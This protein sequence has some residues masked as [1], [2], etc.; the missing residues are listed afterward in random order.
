MKREQGNLIWA[1]REEIAIFEGIDFFTN[2]APESENVTV[3]VYT[4][5]LGT[6]PE[7]SK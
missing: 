6:Y 1:F 2:H 4:S 3:R 5:S 7:L